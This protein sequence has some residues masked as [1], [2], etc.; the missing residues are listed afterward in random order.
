[1]YGQ[2]NSIIMALRIDFRFQG[3]FQFLYEFFPECLTLRIKKY[4]EAALLRN[5][6]A[7]LV[8]IS[9]SVNARLRHF[10]VGKLTGWISAEGVVFRCLFVAKISVG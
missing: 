9:Y 3:H 10:A 1:M 7:K 6:V 5:G 8:L 4:I 2:Q